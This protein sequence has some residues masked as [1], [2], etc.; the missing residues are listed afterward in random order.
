MIFF[1]IHNIHKGTD[2][3]KVLPIILDSFVKYEA[4]KAYSG[5]KQ[6]TKIFKKINPEIS[7]EWEQIKT[8]LNIENNNL[9]RRNKSV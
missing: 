8:N 4:A 3:D 1:L 5:V 9:L 7:L 6:S 2:N